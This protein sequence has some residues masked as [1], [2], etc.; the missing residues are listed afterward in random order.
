MY[1]QIDLS[2]AEYSLVPFELNILIYMH[3]K[4]VFIDLIMGN[5]ESEFTTDHDICQVKEKYVFPV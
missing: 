3:I 1:L 4:I 5:L 2:I